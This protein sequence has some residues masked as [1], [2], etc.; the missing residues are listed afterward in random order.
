M[1]QILQEFHTKISEYA[2]ANPGKL[3]W[4]WFS[5]NEI[6]VEY[7]DTK[8][9]ILKKQRNWAYEHQFFY[10][11]D[12]DEG[13]RYVDGYTDL[14]KVVFHTSEYPFYKSMLSDS[15]LKIDNWNIFKWV[16]GIDKF[17]ISTIELSATASKTIRNWKLKI[18][19]SEIKEI[20]NNANKIHTEKKSYAQKI[21]RYRVNEYL[22]DY[23]NATIKKVT[24]IEKWEF[25]FVVDRLCIENKEKRPEFQKHLNEQD[26]LAIQNVC[27]KFIKKNIF[28]DDFLHRLDE[29]FL[30]QK[31]Q[32]II[33]LGKKILDL[34]SS[35][36]RTTLALPVITTLSFPNNGQLE[37]LWQTYFA[38]YLL[39]LLF[40]YKKVFPKIEFQVEEAKKYPDFL[41]INHYG[42]IDIV[43]IKHHLLPA[44]VKDK[45]H[46]NFSF[47]SDL[48]KAIIQT[49]NYMEALS[50]EK[51][52]FT[53]NKKTK[54]L[55]HTY[56]NDHPRWVII[57][58]SKDH[59]VK[60]M[61]QYTTEQKKQILHDFTKLRN[62]LQ[63]IQIITF[64]EIV[65]MAD[66]YQKNITNTQ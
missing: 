56:N 46:W 41:W 17:W 21:E 28:D 8:S 49:M 9:I 7:E 15:W 12:D 35:D 57:I 19:G 42:G 1:D 62:S 65:E 2:Q 30:K 11:K 52:N 34:K 39:Y 24:S 43:E 6:F 16:C 31:L 55:I 36:L 23:R 29:Y 4:L 25:A 27:E 20:M 51:Y 61:S 47:S 50:K 26:I 32:D 5:D 13:K 54:D 64:D 44:L 53:G 45:S 38:K 33:S 66:D 37:N 3:L 58:S 60:G 18:S 59:L 63:N 22:R 48:S 40:T 10:F 14:K